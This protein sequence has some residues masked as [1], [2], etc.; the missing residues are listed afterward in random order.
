MKKKRILLLSEGFGAGHT[1][2]AHALAISLKRHSAN[3]QTRVMELASFLHPTI[4]PAIISAYH[5]ALM[6]TPKLYGKLYRAKY[7]KSLGRFSQLALHRLF[8]RQTAEVIEHL[9][10]DII[11]CT[12]PFPNAVIAR[13]KRSGL[14]IPLCTVIT[15]YDAHGTWISREANTYL[16]STEEVKRKLLMHGVAPE[17]IQVTGIPVHPNFWTRPDKDSIRAKFGLK[18]MP[19]ALI[20]GGGW[21]IVSQWELLEKLASWRDQVQLIFCLGKNE[22]LLAKLMENERFRHENIHLL[23]FTREVDQLMEVSDVLITKPGGVTCSEGMAK[24][25]PMLFYSPIPG[26]EEE[27]CQYFTGLGVA[28]KLDRLE[29]LDYWF[30][31]MV[32]RYEEFLEKRERNLK[33]AARYRPEQWTNAILQLVSCGEENRTLASS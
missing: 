13:L 22:K 17:Q 20:M 15:D 6:K 7:D 29:D 31:R 23:G 26:Q 28:D 33:I 5:K 25:I 10:P 19:T 9:R 2:A 12:H 3:V 4:V 24:G 11:V 16:V 14:S 32:N 30:D 8:Y 21:G 1:Q 27:N 18:N